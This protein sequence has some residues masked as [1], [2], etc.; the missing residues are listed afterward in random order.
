VTQE[1]RTLRGLYWDRAWTLVDGCTKVSAGC[2]HC[3][4]ESQAA[5]R[6][7]HPNP[8]IREPLVGMIDEQGGWSGLIRLRFDNLEVPLKAKAPK[9]WSIWN[10]LFHECVPFEFVSQAFEVMNQAPQHTFL[11]LT[12]RS[13]RMV[14]FLSRWERIE[15][16]SFDAENVWLGVTAENQQTAN[17]RIPQLLRCNGRHFLSI[18]PMLGQVDLTRIEYDWGGTNPEYFDALRETYYDHDGRLLESVSEEEAVTLDW[19]II[20]TETGP[21]RRPAKIEWIRN[22]IFQCKGSGVPVFVKK[23]E[24]NGRATADMSLWPEDLRLRQYPGSMQ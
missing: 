24:I 21:H 9:V 11:I 6:Q 22:L 15:G 17:E 1:K 7:S 3:W 19:V 23:L 18:E 14:E 10:D 20:G 4:A 13:E 16:R 8:K 12:K 2:D 5:M